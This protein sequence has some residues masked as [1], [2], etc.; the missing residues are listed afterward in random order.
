ML[1]H[2]SCMVSLNELLLK[3]LVYLRNPQCCCFVL[4]LSNISIYN[5]SRIV[6]IPK[7]IIVKKVLANLGAIIICIFI[8]QL[9]NTKQPYLVNVFYYIVIN[10]IVNIDSIKL[11]Q[12]CI[13]HIGQYSHILFFRKISQSEITAQTQ[14]LNTNISL[15]ILNFIGIIVLQMILKLSYVIVDLY[16]LSI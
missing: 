3:H 8:F 15:T 7:F 14:H 5:F 6:S 9:Q 16:L 1:K 12:Y 2:L 4:C 10:W 11:N 13:P